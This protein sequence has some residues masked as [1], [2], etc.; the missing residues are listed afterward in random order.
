METDYFAWYLDEWDKEV[1][2]LVM[3]IMDRLSN[4]DPSAAELNPEKIKDLFK[5]LYQNLVPK[6]IRH[7][8]GEYYTPNWLAELVLNEVEW[9]SKTF[10]KLA[11]EKVS[12]APLDLRLLDPA[13]GSGTFLVLAV[14][15]LR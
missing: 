8:L 5:R 14:S 4:Y 15:R 10:E 11:H 3:N 9:A 2:E 12:L 6:K 7:D 1:A 13:C